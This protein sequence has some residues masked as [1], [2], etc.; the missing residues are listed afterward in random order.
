MKFLVEALDTYEKLDISDKEL[1]RVPKAGELFE[2]SKERL[3]ILLGNNSNKVAFV[4]LIEETV[5]AKE[6]VTEEPEKDTKKEKTTK[7]VQ[8]KNRIK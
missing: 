5:E 3:D 7:K 6:E 1:G 8:K 2:V 4:K